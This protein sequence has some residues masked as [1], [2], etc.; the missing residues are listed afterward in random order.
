MKFGPTSMCL[1]GYASNYIVI[2]QR[3]SNTGY[4][5]DVCWN[6]P[7]TYLAMRHINCVEGLGMTTA[8]DNCV[9]TF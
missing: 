3:V 6:L 2:E 9:V 8:S 4:L 7:K 5:R 1:R